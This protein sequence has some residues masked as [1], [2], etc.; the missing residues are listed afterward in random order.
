MDINEAMA[1]GRYRQV[2]A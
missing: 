2:M 1:D